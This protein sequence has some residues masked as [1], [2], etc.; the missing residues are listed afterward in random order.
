MFSTFNINM[1]DMLNRMTG[2]R[3]SINISKEVVVEAPRP[4]EGRFET[5]KD[6]VSGVEVMEWNQTPKTPAIKMMFVPNIS[7]NVL[8]LSASGDK[9]LATETE[10]AV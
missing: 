6:G 8:Q 9:V 2:G 1:A 4:L 3:Q 5:F 10:K 7:T